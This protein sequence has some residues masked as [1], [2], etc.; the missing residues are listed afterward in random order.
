M[1][2]ID[3]NS[4]TWTDPWYR[5]LPKHAK[6]LFL[7]LWTNNHKNLI[8]MYSIDEETMS[9]ETGLNKKEVTSAL[10]VL[11]PKV[12]YDR[13][14][15]LV[16]V[17]NHVQHQY[18]KSEKISPQ[19]IIGI[20]KCLLAIKHHFRN[21]F[22]SVYVD[23]VSR[24]DELKEIQQLTDIVYRPPIEG[25]IDPPGKDKDKDKG[26]GKD[27]DV[28]Y[29]DALPGWVPKEAWQGFLFFL[30]KFRQNQK[31]FRFHPRLED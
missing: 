14:A 22:L 4:A 27:K 6:L 20:K 7:Y 3:F 25:P 10:E 29:N 24:F 19:I 16:W 18:L 21:H 26:K 13:N 11:S 2:I 17:V 1:S 8:A 28:F 12:F 9:F 31:P 5:K 23:L 15:C 30:A